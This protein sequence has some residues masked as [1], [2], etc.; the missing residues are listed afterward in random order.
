MQALFEG[1]GSEED[2]DALLNTLPEET[3][4]MIKPVSERACKQAAALLKKC[5]TEIESHFEKLGNARTKI[6]SRPRKI[7]TDWEI[8]VRLLPKGGRKSGAYRWETGV[9][10]VCRNQIPTLV[11][12]LWARGGR[13]AE[14]KLVK[15]LGERVKYRSEDYDWYAGSVIVGEEIPFRVENGDNFEIDGKRLVDAV[16][17]RWQMIGKRDVE[18]LFEI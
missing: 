18:K 5:G 17:E 12:Y 4:G 8:K 6:R 3:R 1:E 9:C 16:C 11:L 15:I 2:R 7:E 10:C 14:Q 13:E